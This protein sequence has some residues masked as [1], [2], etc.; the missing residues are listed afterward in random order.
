MDKKYLLSIKE[1]SHLTNVHPKA[2]R[3][4]DIQDILKPYYVDPVSGYRYYS[5]HQK[6]LVWTI[7]LCVKAGIPLKD[8]ASY[9]DNSTSWIQYQEL[10]SR[11]EKLLREQIAL[12]QQYL[13]YVE[14][15]KQ[16]MDRAERL[17][18]SDVLAYHDI[19]AS[20]WYIQPYI[21]QIPVEEWPM[22]FHRMYGELDKL[23]VTGNYT[24]VTEVCQAETR[25]RFFAIQIGEDSS[26]LL[27]EE[28]LLRIPQGQWL[29]KY[30]SSKNP[31]DIWQWSAPHV[32]PENIMI[33]MQTV[34][35]T[36]VYNYVDP[37]LKQSCMLRP[38][39]VPKNIPAE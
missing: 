17:M 5:Y 29:C 3:Y 26:V 20:C 9:I 15:G 11:S 21:G 8:L 12:L 28:C 24:A 18:H 14:H 2:L 37:P 30:A 34:L 1:F 31:E 25:A 6:D 27:P 36:G 32:L 10:F 38:G 22:Y 19:P 16:E 4:Y 35:Y 39:V 7:Q 13:E 33:L 23:G